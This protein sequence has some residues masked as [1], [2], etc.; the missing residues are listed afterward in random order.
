MADPAGVADARFDA[1]GGVEIEIPL[2]PPIGTK[3]LQRP[4]DEPA[5][6]AAT[7]QLI[8]VRSCE[9]LLFDTGSIWDEKK[10]EPSSSKKSD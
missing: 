1:G 10:T 5:G 6:K 9:R 7:L 8:G 4:A 2:P 3:R